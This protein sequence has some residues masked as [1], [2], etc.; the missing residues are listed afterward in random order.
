MKIT[1]HEAA[2]QASH[3]NI[4]L[5]FTLEIDENNYARNLFGLNPK[6]NFIIGFGSALVEN[7]IRDTYN[8]NGITKEEQDA[9]LEDIKDLREKLKQHAEM[10]KKEDDDRA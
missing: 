10:R 7:Y 6:H 4:K 5:D 8:S 2:Q 1:K 9:Y 3:Q